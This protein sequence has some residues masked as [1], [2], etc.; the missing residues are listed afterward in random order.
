[1]NS[2]SRTGCLVDPIQATYSDSRTVIGG[3][4]SI[5]FEKR[6]SSFASLTSGFPSSSRR[7][8]GFI[9]G[10]PTTCALRRGGHLP[11]R[12]LVRRGRHW[13]R[14][15]REAGLSKELIEKMALLMAG[16]SLPSLIWNPDML[17]EAKSMLESSFKGIIVRRIPIYAPP[18]DMRSSFR[19]CEVRHGPRW[20]ASPARR[21][22]R[23]KLK[24]RLKEERQR[25]FLARQIAHLVRFEPA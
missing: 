1:M 23:R 17:N 5:R 10:K 14:S 12:F 21:R 20:P 9:Q 16:A 2:P 4:P 11:E 22:F 25:L 24:N 3:E 13:L 18:G 8:S 6:D 7:S 15:G 19:D